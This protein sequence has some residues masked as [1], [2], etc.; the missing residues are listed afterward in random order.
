[1]KPLLLFLL[2]FTQA[3][4]Q[5]VPLVIELPQSWKDSVVTND[6]LTKNIVTT[7]SAGWPC[8]TAGVT[9]ITKSTTRYYKIFPGVWFAPKGLAIWKR[10]R[11]S[12]FFKRK[13][14]I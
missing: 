3:K 11:P 8:G 13:K 6:W 5:P 12:V 7:G 9:I 10:E 4:A 14:Y 2:L 1:M